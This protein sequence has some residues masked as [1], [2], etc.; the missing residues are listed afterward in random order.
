VL[1]AAFGSRQS[2]GREQKRTKAGSDMLNQQSFHPNG[3]VGHF[4]S[5]RGGAA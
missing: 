3:I 1:L 4:L 2:D 5:P